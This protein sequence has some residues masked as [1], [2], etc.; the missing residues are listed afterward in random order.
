M[1][2]IELKPGKKVYFASD[3]HLGAPDHAGSLIREKKI[4]SWLDSI[5][6]DADTIFLCG[7][8]FDFWFEYNRVVP[9]GY[10]RFFGKLA[11]L[12]D[13]GIRVIV[14]TGNH[15]MWMR[16]YLEVEIGAEVYREP[17]QYLI[18][19]KKFLIGH[20]DGLGPGDYAYKY[21]KVIFESSFCRFLFG[22]VLH[23]N[24]GQFLGYKW[25]S[26]SWKKHLKENDVYNYESPEKEILFLYCKEIEAKEHHDFYVFGHRHFKLDLPVAMN[27]RYIN[28]GDWIR[29]YSYGVFENNDFSLCKYC[30]D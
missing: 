11:S 26:H 1:T 2:K 21:L 17:K 28:L 18:N 27:A 22:R 13:K 23:A 4:I 9:K 20:G 12:T 30:V 25:A 14:F 6:H 8:L 5:E 19:G 15:D 10:V 24:L 16:D 7:D 3:F 29:F